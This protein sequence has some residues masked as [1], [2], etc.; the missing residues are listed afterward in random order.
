M[1]SAVSQSSGCSPLAPV[2]FVARQVQRACEF[3]LY[4]FK[5]AVEPLAG[6][7][8]KICVFRDAA[9]QD[10]CSRWFMAPIARGVINTWMRCQGIPDRLDAF[11][12]T[13]LSRSEAF[14]AEFADIQTIRTADGV[15][16]S[17]AMYTPQRFQQWID[18]NGGE[19]TGEWI[20]P[21]T[22]QDW[23]RLQRLR[24]FRCFE[25]VGQAFRVPPVTPNLENKCIL[26]CQGFG[27]TIAMD[28]YFIGKHLAAGIQYAIFNWRD[29]ISA[30]GQSQD[31][32]TIYQALL[33]RGFTPQQIIPMGTCRSTFVISRLKE[34]HHQDG[35]N[36][37]MIHAPPSLR[38]TIE[39]Q[40]Y[41]AS[42]IGLL[43]LGT[44]ENEGHDFDTLRKLRGLQHHA[45]ASVCLITSE[46]DRTILEESAREL[47]REVQ[48]V[49]P[50]D[51]IV[52]PRGNGEGDPHFEEPLKN[53]FV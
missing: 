47:T 26:R 40:S 23:Q 28:K 8:L 41:L 21:R 53:P 36:V 16:L 22:L 30:R 14:L 50:A 51:L 18:A 43:G 29:D 4:I 42:R 52:E 3:I 15:T 2:Y 39:H 44:I 20:R 19:R 24:E 46:G 49:G 33:Q 32:E 38:Q 45:T 11:D 17:W 27:R 10:R 9:L 6:Y 13:R 5:K 37:V 12:A 1:T 35:L 34:L 48:R 31:A 7:F 25:E